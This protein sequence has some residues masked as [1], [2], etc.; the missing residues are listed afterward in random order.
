MRPAGSM[1]RALVVFVAMAKGSP[2]RYWPLVRVYAWR[3]PALGGP[4]PLEALSLEVGLDAAPRFDAVATATPQ[5]P[6]SS[7]GRR[8]LAWLWLPLACPLP[9]LPVR[10]SSLVPVPAEPGRAHSDRP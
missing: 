2:Q 5:Q 1:R 9:P 10:L 4:A 7:P 6:L 3:W 8:P